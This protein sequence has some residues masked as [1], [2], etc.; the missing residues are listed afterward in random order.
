VLGTAHIKNLGPGAVAVKFDG[1]PL[2]PPADNQFTLESGDSYN[3][4]SVN[5]STIGLRA[6]GDCEV[7]VIAYLAAQGDIR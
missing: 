3:V 7:Q 5:F 2:V 6:V 1:V 4:D